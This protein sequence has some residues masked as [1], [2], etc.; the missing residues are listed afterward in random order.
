MPKLARLTILCST[1]S[2]LAPLAGHPTL[3]SVEINFCP[4]EDIRVLLELPSL[5]WV[6][7]I[8]NPLSTESWEQVLPTLRAREIEKWLRPPIVQVRSQKE[9]QLTRAI[10]ERGV[11]LCWGNVPRRNPTFVKP[12]P[13]GK[14]P[15][16]F[17]EF[18]ADSVELSLKEDNLAE[19]P[20]VTKIAFI[21]DWAVQSTERFKVGW[22][23]GNS[24]DA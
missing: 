11:R 8:G 2:D 18:G 21:Q 6:T 24:R 5:H 23:A 16:E 12:G 19:Q 10:W 22:W 1:V 3:E 17:L 15:V 9:W 14:R 4:V 7:L 13:G 20:M